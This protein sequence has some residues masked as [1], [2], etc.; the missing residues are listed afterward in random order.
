[1][2]K[3][4]GRPSKHTVEFMMV[5]AEQVTNGQMTYR[6][7]VKRYGVSH[8]SVSHWVKKYKGQSLH[9]MNPP[10][11]SSIA[12]TTAGHEAALETENRLLKHELAELYM[13]VQILKKAQIFAERAKKDASSIVTSENFEQYKKGVK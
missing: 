1:M 10:K 7:A 5:V 9:K 4:T 13:Q 8:G 6:D 2:K 11:K 3:P 12:K